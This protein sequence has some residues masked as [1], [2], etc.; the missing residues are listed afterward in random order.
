MEEI[1]KVI[2]TAVK[3][4]FNVA[5]EPELTRPDEQFGE[6][7]TNVA[8]QLA[9][10]VGK[11]PREIAEALVGKI[12]SP[13]ITKAEVA[14]PGFLNMTLS[15]GALAQSLTT[16]INKPYKDKSVVIETN[17]PNP[18]KAMHIGHAFNAILADTLANLIETGGA[19][20]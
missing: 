15:D 6:Y 12:V 14:G 19:H 3:D 13:S 1:R 5:V 9:G 20:T 7:S 8:L 16:E 18:F 2:Q 11:N 10:T 4:V 17:N